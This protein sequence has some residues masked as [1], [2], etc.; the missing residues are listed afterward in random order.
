MIF[1]HCEGVTTAL[2]ILTTTHPSLLADI[3]SQPYNAAP[4]PITFAQTRRRTEADDLAR[5]PETIFGFF[6]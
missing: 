1:T 6:G 4:P 5:H 3:S 2:A